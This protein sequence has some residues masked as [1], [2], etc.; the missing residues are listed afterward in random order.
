MSS[1]I[2]PGLVSIVIPCY[3][4]ERF[5]TEA[6]ES[7]LRQ[8]YDPLEIIVVDD[9]SPDSCAA[10]ADRYARSDPRVRLVQRPQNG[11]V[12]RAFNSGFEAARGEF[13]ARLAQDDVFEP[14]AV[15]RMTAGLRAAGPGAG[16]AYCDCC[17]IDEAGNRLSDFVTAQPE[18]ALRFRNDILLCVLWTRKVWQTIGGFNPEYD[19]AEDFEYWLRLRERFTLVK[20]EGP[21]ALR[22]RSHPEMGCRQFS[23]KCVEATHRAIAENARQRFF[24][25]DR[26]WAQRRIAK[27]G[28]HQTM[29]YALVDRQSYAKALAQGL[30]SLVVWPFPLPGYVHDSKPAWARARMIGS[31]SRKVLLTRLRAVA[32]ACVACASSSFKPA[33]GQDEQQLQTED[34]PAPPGRGPK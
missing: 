32:S 24:Q 9:A 33:R 31:L 5:L 8:T 7:C 1:E 25:F 26:R 17:F 27:S 12:S 19:T 11:G 20:C 21:P 18:Q 30:L 34:S 13:F 29:A 28:V 23:E 2:V 10:L 6:I 14:S 4:G 3:K 22:W 16:L 15:A